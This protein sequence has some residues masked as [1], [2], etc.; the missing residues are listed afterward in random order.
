LPQQTTFVSI[1]DLIETTVKQE[2]IKIG[3]T[4]IRTSFDKYMDGKYNEEEGAFSIIGYD[5]A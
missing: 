1:C 4:D 5:S 2:L 3:A